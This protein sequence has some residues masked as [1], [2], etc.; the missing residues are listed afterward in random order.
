[1]K[2]L[3]VVLKGLAFL[4][5]FVGIAFAGVVLLEGAYIGQLALRARLFGSDDVREAQ[6]DGHPYKGQAWY[7]DFLNAR[8]ALKEKY[9]PWRAYWAYGMTTEYLTVLDDGRR[10]TKPPAAPAGTPAGSAPQGNEARPMLFLGGSAMWGYTSRD[11]QTIPALVATELGMTG[12]PAIRNLAQ[13]GYTIGHELAALTYEL[14]RWNGPPPEVVVFYDGINDIRTAMLYGEP[15]HAFFEA[16]LGRLYEVESPRG[17]FGAMLGPL[18]RSA[19]AGR[20]LMALGAPNPWAVKARTPDVCPALG[21]YYAATARTAKGLADAWGFGLLFVQQPH[22]ASSKKPPTPFE[23]T[24]MTPDDEMRWATECSQA[25]DRA[26]AGADVPYVNDAALF[27]SSTDSVFLDRF[28]HVTEAANAIIARDLATR[29]RATR[30]AAGARDDAPAS[31]SDRV[32]RGASAA[33]D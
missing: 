6:V 25:I 22:H 17:F 26:M 33:R 14:D 23:A 4:W 7:R 12:E 21:R 2:R 11:T 19:L 29:I 32:S 9:D 5:L 18:E 20:V 16:K 3:A 8:A 15:G 28:G 24:F 31:Q 27:D 30:V 1:M 13:P 10:I